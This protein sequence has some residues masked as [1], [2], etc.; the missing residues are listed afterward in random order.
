VSNENE[1]IKNYADGWI[2][3]RKGTDAPAFLK[4]AFPIIGLF[5]TAYLVLYMTGEVDHTGRGA[6]VQKFNE[7]TE[8]SPMLMYIIAAMALVYVIAVVLFAIRKFKED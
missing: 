1:Q 8:T 3:E 6:I 7:A 4:I 2:Q 5:C